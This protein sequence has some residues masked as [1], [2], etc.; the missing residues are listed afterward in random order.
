MRV[1]FRRPGRP[2][3]NGITWMSLRDQ[4]RQVAHSRDH[5]T[6]YRAVAAP[7]LVWQAEFHDNKQDPDGKEASLPRRCPGDGHTPGDCRTSDRRAPASGRLA[8]GLWKPGGT[9][10][11]RHLGIH[12]HYPAVARAGAN[13]RD[14][15][16]GFLFP[17]A[18]S[19]RP[20]LL[21]FRGDHRPAD[22]DRTCTRPVQ[23]TAGSA[24][25]LLKLPDCPRFAGA[26]LVVVRGGAVLSALA[27]HPPAAW[28]A[29][30][31][32]GL[33][34][35]AHHG[36]RIPGSLGTASVADLSKVCLRVR[37]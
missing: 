23:R 9:S 22:P 10:L 27:D 5:R 32:I 31:R 35:D 15:L 25:V 8:G 26:Q 34:P 21:R 17:P 4:H 29:Q 3:V 11:L 33:R 7:K 19:H 1:E 24:A 14:R 2:R 18:V 13:R 20:G 30:I 16:E 37:L 28:I 6:V 12:H 36:A